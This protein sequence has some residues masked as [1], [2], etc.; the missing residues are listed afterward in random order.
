VGTVLQ[1]TPQRHD[2]CQRR[3]DRFARADLCAPYR[4]LRAQGMAQRQAAQALQGPRPPLQAWRLWH[5]TLD[6]YPQVAEF[7]QKGPGLAF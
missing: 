1:D 2:D 7:F 5:D 6:L 4:A 3:W